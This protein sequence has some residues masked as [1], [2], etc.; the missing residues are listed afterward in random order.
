MS[1]GCEIIAIKRSAFLQNLHEEARD[2]LQEVECAYPKDDEL[3]KAFCQQKEW[4]S[5]REQ[6]ISSLVDKKRRPVTR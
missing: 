5:N 3:F 1:S 4:K 2:R 6:I